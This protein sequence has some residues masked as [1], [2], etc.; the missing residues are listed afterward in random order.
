MRRQ[1]LAALALS[2][3][4]G[5]AV[6]P[7]VAFGPPRLAVDPFFHSYARAFA[8]YCGVRQGEDLPTRLSACDFDDRC[9]RDLCAEMGKR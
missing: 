8:A 5:S 6:R 3:G 7:R 9:E 2:L 4:C 1:A